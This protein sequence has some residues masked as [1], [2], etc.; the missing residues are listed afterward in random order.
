VIRLDSG[1]TKNGDGRVFPFGVHPD[2]RPLLESQAHL[3]DELQRRR[4]QIIP[5]IFHKNGKRLRNFRKVWSRARE[6]AELPD[7]IPHDLRRTAAR[8]FDRAGVRRSTAM[9]LMGHK[10]E[11]IFLR[12]SVGDHADLEEGVARVGALNADDDSKSTT[13]HAGPP[14]TLGAG[15]EGR[16]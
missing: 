6:A 16:A 15:D 10:T 1:T 8:N 7:L 13:R 2:L 9:K 4:R 11:S 14:R 3:T 5:W 12:Y